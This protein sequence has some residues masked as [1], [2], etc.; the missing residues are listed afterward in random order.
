MLLVSVMIKVRFVQ[1][2]IDK[3]SLPKIEHP[4]QH[5]SCED[6]Y[7]CTI[8][9]KYYPVSSMREIMTARNLA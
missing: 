7:H 5:V 1:M 2:R 8:F 9:A 3:P 4:L 6:L